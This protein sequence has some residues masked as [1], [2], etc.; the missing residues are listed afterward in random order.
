MKRKEPDDQHQQKMDAMET[1]ENPRKIGRQDPIQKDQKYD[2]QLRLWGNNGQQALEQANVC[3]I[4]ATATGTETLKCLVLPGVGKF[5]VVDNAMVT[6][7][8]TGN[9]FFVDVES[10]GKPRAQVT[11]EM[12]QELNPDSVGGWIKDD[13]STIVDNDPEFFSK[14]A[15]VVCSRVSEKDMLKIGNLL[16][17]KNIPMVITD[18]IGYLGYLRVVLKEHAIIQAHPDNTLEDLRLDRPFPE[19]IDYFDNI[20]LSEMDHLQHSHTPYLVILYKALKTWQQTGS[21]WPQNY[22]EKCQIK[23]LVKQCIMKNEEGIPLDEENFEEALRNANNVFISTRV[24][25]DIQEVLSNQMVNHP[26]QSEVNAKFWIL[27]CALKDFV[28]QDGCLPLRGSLPDMFSDSKRY[29]ELQN[30][31]RN[32]AE[33][34]IQVVSEFVRE[35]LS[36]LQLPPGFIPEEEIRMFCKNSSFLKVLQGLSYHDEIKQELSEKKIKEVLEMHQGFE[37]DIYIVFRTFYNYLNDMH[38]TKT[39]VDMFG[40]EANIEKLMSKA[41]ELIKGLGLTIEAPK[42]LF[43]EL[44]RVDFNELHTLA[45]IMG[46]TCAQEIIKLIT[47][48]Y[49]P[50][51]NTFVMNQIS[52]VTGTLE[53]C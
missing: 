28:N 48:Q 14:F 2:R 20:N 41:E 30:I 31:Y 16:W 4:N 53:L 17:R 1:F 13:P 15:V 34:D 52:N 44:A 38:G 50:L 42:D 49:V 26:L 22:K 51:N 18:N 23:E 11:C 5:V 33:S 39:N 40:T 7:V 25:T 32:K 35:A 29:I 10:I 19:L 3:L 24:P 47:K 43:L 37:A 27:V 45:A 46:G 36:D 6:T 8:D 9:N 12:L 21:S